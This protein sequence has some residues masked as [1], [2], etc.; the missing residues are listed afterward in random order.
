MDDRRPEFG[1]V[2]DEDDLLLGRSRVVEQG[3]LD[4][5]DEPPEI[6]DPN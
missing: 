3:V 4:L 1:S 6:R 5:I 2:G